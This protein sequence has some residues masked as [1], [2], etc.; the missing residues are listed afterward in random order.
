M[1]YP[2]V[3]PPV[4]VSLL[5]GDLKMF[6]SV[7]TNYQCADAEISSG[8]SMTLCPQV[9]GFWTPSLL[10]SADI[11]GASS[12]LSLRTHTLVV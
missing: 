6:L 5:A 9:D 3:P 12:P 4:S 11:D 7:S 10:Q 8:N 1:S 2:F